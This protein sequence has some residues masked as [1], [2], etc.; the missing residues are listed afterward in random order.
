M[1]VDRTVRQDK[2]SL[3]IKVNHTVYRPSGPTTVKV[4]DHVHFMEQNGKC[5]VRPHGSPL[6]SEMW[7]AQ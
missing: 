7:S 4:G 1:P 2:D 5:F 3:W 6:P